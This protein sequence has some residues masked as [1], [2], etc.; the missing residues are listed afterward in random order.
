M[1]FCSG[2]RSDR[3][4]W[5]WYVLPGNRTACVVHR[6][7]MM[8]E[9]LWS[10]IK[11][12]D[13]STEESTKI[14]GTHTQKMW[15]PVNNPTSVTC[16]PQLQ[17][18]TDRNNLLWSKTRLKPNCENRKKMFCVTSAL[19]YC[20]AFRHCPHVIGQLPS[21]NMFCCD[22]FFRFFSPFFLG[23]VTQLFDRH[24]NDTFFFYFLLV[25]L[26][27]EGF[28]LASPGK[29]WLFKSFKCVLTFFSVCSYFST[30]EW[31]RLDILTHPQANFWSACV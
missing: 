17:P 9:N 6:A 12:T 14:T 21:R 2:N 5:P 16:G 25:T 20:G 24:P 31:E 11:R 29:S 10:L 1:F 4:K 28:L 22:I 30:T 3:N 23:F 15:V 7:E 19:H 27:Q 13:H 8:I 18:R 26:C